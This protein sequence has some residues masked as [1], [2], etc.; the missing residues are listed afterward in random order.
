MLEKP[1]FPDE[2]IIAGVQAEYGLRS[3]AIAFLPLGVDRNTAVYRLT[4]A[5]G[6][7]YF[8]KLRSGVFDEM[9]VTL[10][11]LLSDQGSAHIIAPLATHTGQLWADIDA[12]KMILY[13]F[14]AGHNG[15]EVD[16]SDQ[17][18]I[19]FGAA[20]RHIHAVTLSPALRSHIQRETYSPRW[21]EIAT[22]FMT[23]IET[24]VYAD[25]V[26]DKAAVFLQTK[27]AEV[28]DLV[29]RA[30]RYAQ[31]LQTHSPEFVLC[32]SDLHAGNIL[33]AA[34]SAF[35]LVDWD[36]PIL[37]PQERDLMYAGGGQF[38]H[39][40][41]PHAEEELFYQGYGPTA[42]DPSALAY[43]RYERIVEDI[44]VYC[45]QLLLSNEGGSDREQALRYLMSNFEPDGTIA[46]ADRADTALQNR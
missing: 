36:N 4:V 26:A 7:S 10:P 2:K 8:L 16:L 39:A 21:R 3:A 13:P 11:R 24:E 1:D 20:L 5:D 46:I 23:R 37:A 32:H 22:A 12:F 15:Y 6:T 33:V 38:G 27:Q 41:T 40:R 45:E 31:A 43:Y 29:E 17:Q 9:S 14:V 42:I 19:E 34:G 30:E 35:Y 28:L 44:A 18:W 25:P